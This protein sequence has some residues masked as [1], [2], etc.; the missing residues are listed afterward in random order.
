V[1][2]TFGSTAAIDLGLIPVGQTQ[3]QAAAG[4]NQTLTGRDVNA[5][6]VDG[7]FDTFV[8]LADAIDQFNLPELERLSARLD[9]DLNRALF[10]RSDLGA[11]G[12]SL[13]AIQARLEDE[14]IQ[15]KDTLSKEIEA[16]LTQVISDMYGRQA[17][18]QASLQLMARTFELT[19]LNYL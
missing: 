15:L 16:D 9:V 13:D 3:V 14:Q 1:Q 5:Q 18:L 4:A 10:A 2:T 6:E 19:L 11:R 12:Q 17:S 8:R 7:V